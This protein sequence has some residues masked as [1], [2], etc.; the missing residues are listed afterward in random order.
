[1]L[2]VKCCSE[3][4]HHKVDDKKRYKW[5]NAD[6]EGFGQHLNSVNWNI[7]FCY[8]Q[9]AEFGWLTLTLFGKLLTI[10]YYTLCPEK[11]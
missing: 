6:F 5:F 11:K 10:L 3:I 1:M 2:D 9:S 4:K 8:N 7:I